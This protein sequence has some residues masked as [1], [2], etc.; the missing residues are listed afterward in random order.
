MTIS[1]PLAL[2]LALLRPR[3]GER[4]RVGRPDGDLE[5]DGEGAEVWP[6]FAAFGGGGGVPTM[7]IG[8]LIPLEVVKY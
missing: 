2:L 8:A 6:E 3:L 7:T 5:P 1:P 4:T